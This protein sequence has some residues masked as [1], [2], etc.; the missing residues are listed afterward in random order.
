MNDIRCRTVFARL[1]SPTRLLA[2]VTVVVLAVARVPATAGQPWPQF[3]G[4]EGDGVAVDQHPPVQFGEQEN[5][6]WKVDLPG[7]A[8]SSPVVADGHVW[9]TTALERTVNEEERLDLLRRT[10]NSEKKFKQLAIAKAIDL[11]LLVVNF[12]TGRLVK[13][14]DIATIEQPDA[15]HSL[16]SYASPTP[17]VDD[18][19]IY[20]HFGT[21]GTYAFKRSDGL[22][23]GSPTALW[24]RVM[25]IQHAVGPGSSPFLYDGKLI[26]IQDGMDRQYVAAL[27]VETGETSW[28]TDRPPMEAP[29]G[30]QKKAYCTPVA[31]TDSSGREQLLCMGSQWMVSLDPKTGEEWWRLYH[32][33]GFSV[34]PRPVVSEDRGIVY[35]ATGFGKPQLWAVRIDGSGDVTETH[36][37]WTVRRGIPAKPSPLLHD[38]LV[39]VVDDNGV[40]SCFDAADGSPVWKERL[41]GKFSASPL[42]A[43]GHLYFANHEGQVFVLTPG[44]DSSVVETNTLPG[45]IMASPA[46]VDDALLVRTDT[47]LY[48]FEDQP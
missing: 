30:D 21:F 8:W 18:T 6:R 36:V 44:R 2:V 39:Y 48:R 9:L 22:E 35:F 13:T 27:D 37:V 23:K 40:A 20:C 5:Q 41:G 17:V 24:Q 28:E 15:I 42:F 33:K 3:R 11:K 29:S 46:A 26:L 25:P 14:I 4:P 34:V 31:V 47:S 7:K 45:Q 12:Q 32:G 19:N 16:N 10:K 1:R 38:G 43:G